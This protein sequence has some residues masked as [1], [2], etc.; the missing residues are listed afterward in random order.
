MEQNNLPTLIL[1]G[2]S[3]STGPFLFQDGETTETIDLNA[4]FGPDPTESGVFDVSDVS[5]STFAKLLQA[6]SVPTLLVARSHTIKFA[7]S[8]FR[9][10][11]RD[12]LDLQGATFSSL[13]PNPREAR[14]AQLLLE[15]V[16]EERKPE[17]REKVLQI[18]R[19]RLWARM[20]L[21]TI[22][23]GAERM[24]LVQ[25]ENLTAQKRLLSIQKYKKLVS[26]FPIGIAEFALPR[27][28]ECS[29]PFERLLSSVLDARVVDGNDKFAGIYSRRSIS[30]LMGTRLGALLPCTNKI[31]LLYKQWIHARFPI[32]SFESRETD[33]SGGVRFFEN[34]LIGNVNSQRLS[35]LWWVKLD[36]S[37]KKKTQEEIVK[38][39]KI[40]SLGILAG[41]IAHDFNNLLT[42]I[43]G[44]ISLAQTYLPPDNKA[45]DRLEAAVRASKQ[46]QEL[47]QQL[48]TFSKGGLP[49]RKTASITELVRDSV[50]FVLRG[51]N[52]RSAISIPQDLWSVH[53][54]PGQVSQVLNNLFINALQAMPR[55][56][57][58]TVQAENCLV[59]AESVTHIRPGKYV[60]I[61]IKDQGVGIAPE[62]IQKIFDP[63]FTTKETG[64]GLGLATA[65]SIIKKHDGLITVS[66]EVGVGTVFYIYLPAKPDSLTAVDPAH[67]TEAKA[68]YMGKILVM[69]DEQLIRDLAGEIL[70]DLGYEASVVKDG[71]EAIAAYHKAMR[72]GRPFDAVIMDLTIPGGMGGKEAFE[73]IREID[74]EARAIVS[75]GYS[76]DPIMADFKKH[77]FVGVLAKPYT[78]DDLRNQLK[79]VFEHQT[80]T[81]VLT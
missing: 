14:Q 25:I 78:L 17:V 30:E 54:D 49:I 55:G 68:G 26:I 15:K 66:S 32:R 29:Q 27:Q 21:R 72:S 62:N 4:L 31:E 37:E 50:G 36:V 34:T 56:G 41:G 76:H 71:P 51:S 22:R 5:H 9:K 43:L 58:I 69:D 45:F 23:L 6:L 57:T 80:S 73:R 52:V 16:F 12:S 20:H 42:G 77:G 2:D 61:R 3:D 44:N 81:V 28:L 74:P 18:R 63:Y 46:S 24:V 33:L 65:Y 35:G 75:S 40:E 38:S 8:A 47:T 70:S 13:F 60:R 39:Q 67:G 48:L 53:I 64:S 1:A 19:M 7:N 10:T 11:I 59:D 79:A